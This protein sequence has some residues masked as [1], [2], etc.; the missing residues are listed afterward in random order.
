MGLMPENALHV[1]CY[2][3]VPVYNDAIECITVCFEGSLI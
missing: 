1:S 2:P 3:A